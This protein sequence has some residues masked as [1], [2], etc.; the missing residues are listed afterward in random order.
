MGS[1]PKEVME[2]FEWGQKYNNVKANDGVSGSQE[3]LVSMCFFARLA[4]IQ[5]PCCLECIYNESYHKEDCEG[6]AVWRKDANKIAHPDSLGENIL[7]VPCWMA[8]RLTSSGK[9]ETV[10]GW[11]WNV[12]QKR[13]HCVNTDAK[14]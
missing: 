7:M 11:T 13:F 3:L 14:D 1:K 6:W 2:P 5:P 12:D 10:E 4:V 9:S 8:K